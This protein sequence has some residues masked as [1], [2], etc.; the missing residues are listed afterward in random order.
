MNE[1]QLVETLESFGDGVLVGTPTSSEIFARAHVVKDGWL[2]LYNLDPEEMPRLVQY[3]KVV[4]EGTGVSLRGPAGWPVWLYPLDDAI[5][6][7][8][9]EQAAEVQVSRSHA[10]AQFEGDLS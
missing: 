8:Y 4:A 9:R 1:D 10:Q 3:Q 5:D 6:P 7:V 2:A